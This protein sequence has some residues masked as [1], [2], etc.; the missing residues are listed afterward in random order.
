MPF[1]RQ[2]SWSFISEVALL[3]IYFICYLLY[4]QTLKNG[5]WV[6]LFENTIL[7]QHRIIASILHITLVYVV[8]VN[9]LIILDEFRPDTSGTK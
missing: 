2:K 8:N 3:S 7:K 4:S 5:S 6:S 9:G 1:T